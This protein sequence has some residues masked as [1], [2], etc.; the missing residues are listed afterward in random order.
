M[1]CL[2]SMTS[3]DARCTREMKSRIV[4][5]N[6]HSTIRRLFTSKLDLTLRKKL[7]KCCVWSMAMYGGEILTLRTV[8]HI[9]MESFEMWCCVRRIEKSDY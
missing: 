6:Q 9:Y 2:G 5:A 4:V 8:D 3:Y 7:V 1:S